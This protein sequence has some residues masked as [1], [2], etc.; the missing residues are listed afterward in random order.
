MFRHQPSGVWA[1]YPLPTG[2]GSTLAET[3]AEAG[4]PPTI[5]A[6]T[7][8][9]LVAGSLIVGANLN[10]THLHISAA[11]CDGT[12]ENSYGPTWNASLNHAC[13]FDDAGSDGVGP[14]EVVADLEINVYTS[15]G[16]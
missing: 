6:G 5:T 10:E 12:G 2:P 9:E 13:D 4:P 11:D 3:V 1:S 7:G 8:L 14:S 15:G 16:A